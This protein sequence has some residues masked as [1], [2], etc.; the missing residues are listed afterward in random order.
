MCG[1]LKGKKKHQQTKKTPKT[2]KPPPKKQ[3]TKDLQKENILETIR[4]SFK[5]I[6]FHN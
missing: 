2:P 3:P 6:F 1:F 4:G 5:N